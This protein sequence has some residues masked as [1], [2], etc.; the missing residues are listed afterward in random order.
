MKLKKGG[1]VQKAEEADEALKRSIQNY[2]LSY[3]E[4]KRLDDPKV[5]SDLL[6]KSKKV[7]EG[8]KFSEVDWVFVRLLISTFFCVW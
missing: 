3:P 6:S 1:K 7:K 8:K 4:G 2:N 5:F